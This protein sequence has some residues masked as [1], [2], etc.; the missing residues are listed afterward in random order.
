MFV[1]GLKVSGFRV[2]ALGCIYSLGFYAF[3]AN[4][5]TLTFHLGELLPSGVG[6][7]LNKADV[8]RALG[9]WIL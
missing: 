6:C 5:P 7:G 2:Q 4:P 3:G 8:F 9:R 1:K